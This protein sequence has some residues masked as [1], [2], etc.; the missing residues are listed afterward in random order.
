MGIEL[1]LYR[2]RIGLFAACKRH[3]RGCSTGGKDKRGKCVF[4][5]ALGLHVML[6]L[7]IL[8]SMTAISGI[9]IA[10]AAASHVSSAM[11]DD[12]VCMMSNIEL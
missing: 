11:A 6:C 9:T 8:L 10:T 2:A 1:T 3:G 4:S 12:N 7:A 5:L